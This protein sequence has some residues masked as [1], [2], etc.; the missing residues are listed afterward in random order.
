MEMD[1]AAVL[2]PLALSATRTVNEAEV[3]EV[4]VPDI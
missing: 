4:G 3:A 2:L 1:N